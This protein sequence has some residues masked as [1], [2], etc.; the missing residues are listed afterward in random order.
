MYLFRELIQV[1]LP[2]FF[3]AATRNC[4]ISSLC[5]MSNEK[6]LETLLKSEQWSRQF[7][8]FSYI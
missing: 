2:D 1:Q 8:K 6:T 4:L 3:S 5:P 7:K